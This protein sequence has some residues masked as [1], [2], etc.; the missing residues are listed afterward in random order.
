MLRCHQ[1]PALLLPPYVPTK[2]VAKIVFR[3]IVTADPEG[4]SRRFITPQ[5][6]ALTK[7]QPT[8]SCMPTQTQIIASPRISRRWCCDGSSPPHVGV[9]CPWQENDRHDGRIWVRNRRSGFYG[10]LPVEHVA[11]ATQGP[12]GEYILWK[13]NSDIPGS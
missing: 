12:N 4:I 8:A 7:Y 6:K 5:I 2:W 10:T 11:E 3:P 9:S 13:G 1:Q